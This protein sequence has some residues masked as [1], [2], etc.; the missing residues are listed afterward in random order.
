MH[1]LAGSYG[2]TE[3]GESLPIVLRNDRSL[4]GELD[5]DGE[6][7]ASITGVGAYNATIQGASTAVC[8]TVVIEGDAA[9]A[10][11]SSALRKLRLEDAPRPGCF[12]AATLVS[13]NSNAV[14][15]DLRIDADTFAAVFFSEQCTASTLSRSVI[16]QSANADDAAV[17]GQK[18]A[19]ITVDQ[20]RF[21]GVQGGLKFDAGGTPLAC[22]RGHL[23]LGTTVTATRFAACVNPG[24][25]VSYPHP[26][27]ARAH[28]G[29]ARS[30]RQAQRLLV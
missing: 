12:I 19:R 20:C 13:V 5:G 30:A 2:V 8:A 3:S 6:P 23:V 11:Q 4:T 29:H 21:E 26:R 24:N 25:D 18:G 27:R 7:T 10:G 14:V 15:S 16:R 22:P 1:A 9:L 17:M 28:P